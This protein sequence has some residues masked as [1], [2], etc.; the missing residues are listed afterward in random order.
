MKT[1]LD[2]LTIQELIE[3]SCGDYTILCDGDELPAGSEV[4]PK[5]KAIIAEYRSIASPT[6]ARVEL[7][8]SESLSKYQM[9]EKCARICM[10]LCL[11]GRHDLAREVLVQLGVGEEHLTT[12]EAITARCQAI[13]GEVKY[14]TERIAERKMKSAKAVSADQTRREWYR[15]I[16]SVMSILKVPIDMSLNAAIYAN[17]VRQAVEHSKAMAKMPPSAR[18]FM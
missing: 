4:L 9:K 7:M 1:R 2:Q 13:I 18:M 11:K 5:V 16:A 12:D 3:L 15:E 6:Q 14:E 17:L 10:V 8:E